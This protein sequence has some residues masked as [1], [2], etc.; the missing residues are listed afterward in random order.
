MKKFSDFAD[1]KPFDGD[2]IP[3][4]DVLNQEI[5]VHGY[6][7]SP[8]KKKEGTQYITLQIEREGK[9]YIIFTGSTVLSAQVQK[10]QAE[11]PFATIIKKINDFYTFT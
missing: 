7:A 6:R 4:S 11:L 9:R 3:I 10:Y 8:S 5:V 2:K 1:E